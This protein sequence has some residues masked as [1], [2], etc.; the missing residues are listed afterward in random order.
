MQVERAKKCLDFSATVYILHILTA[1]I[2]VGF[3]RAVTW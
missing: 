1:W 3:P 2:C